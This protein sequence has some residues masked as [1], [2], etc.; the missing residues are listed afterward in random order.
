MGE[1]GLKK[2]T[3]Q[4]FNPQNQKI[5]PTLEL[6]AITIIVL[7][8]IASVVIYRYLSSLAELRKQAREET[9]KAEILKMQMDRYLKSIMNKEERIEALKKLSVEERQK[10]YDEEARRLVLKAL[11]YTWEQTE[12]RELINRVDQF[13]KQINR[14]ALPTPPVQ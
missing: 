13:E 8:I 3:A 12:I 11:I 1:T 7:T 5:M 14:A 4:K 2:S 6:K 9:R 10:F